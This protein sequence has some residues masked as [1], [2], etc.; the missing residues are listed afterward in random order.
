MESNESQIEVRVKHQIEILN[1][2]RREKATITELANSSD[3]SFTA[4]SKIV[5]ELVQERLLIYSGKNKTSGRG[6]K[7]IGVEINNDLGVVC[8][9]DFASR[10][11]RI[12]LSTLDSKIV[13]EEYIPAFGLITKELLNKVEGIIRKLLDAPE[14][15]KRPLLSICIV[16]P[17]IIRPDDYSFVDSRLV[18]SDHIGKVNPV[19]YFANA[20]DVKVE[21]HNDVRI[22]C[23]GELKYGV[24]P[25]EVFNGLFIHL[26]H[27]SG[28]ALIINGKIYTGSHNSSGETACYAENSGDEI[29][30][31]SFWNGRFY[32]LGEINNR[33]HELNIEKEGKYN[34]D[35]KRNFNYDLD[36]ILEGFNNNDKS[37]VR[38]VEESAKRNAITIIGLAT[39]LDVEF[40]VIEGKIL[41]LGEHYVNLMRKYISDF[42]QKDLRTRI[43][44]STLKEDC[45]VLGACYKA[46]SIFLF[47]KLEA[48]AKKRTKS[49]KFVLDKSFKEL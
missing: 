19:S 2:L 21:M 35:L 32:P 25:K 45:E 24:F 4:M 30:N 29:L 6:R 7:P 3:I 17:G 20:F 47:D 36:K 39:I 12:I 23:Y 31:S 5:D 15:N 46:T 40:I 48:I 22:G 16:S 41:S 37:I 49:S 28:L 9:I 38:A 14:V 11:A 43:I 18:S 27:A 42:N 10:D 33:I 8:V 34:S 13:V 1:I 44:I 26:G